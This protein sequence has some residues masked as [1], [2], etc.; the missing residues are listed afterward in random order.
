MRENTI[1]RN[2]THGLSKHRLCNTWRHIKDRC[3]NPK[4]SDAK[5]YYFKGIKVCDEW[6]NDYKKF[7]DWAMSN[8]YQDNLTI[9]RKDYTGNYCPDNCT[10][11]PNSEQ[12]CNKSDNHL[13]TAFGETKI[14]S[15]W[16]NDSR[17]IISKSEFKHRIRLGIDPEKAMSNQYTKDCYK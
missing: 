10:W 12:S 16:P 2:T 9:E 8:G 1:K 13:I 14:I 4:N 11:I 5:Y 6:L 15:Q 3:Y 7:Y 17:C